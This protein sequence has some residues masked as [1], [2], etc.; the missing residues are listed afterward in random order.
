MPSCTKCHKD[1]PVAEFRKK[2]TSERRN[3]LCN[4]C[5]DIQLISFKRQ[6][7][8]NMA[9]VL[10]WSRMSY[11]RFKK[12]QLTSIHVQ[13]FSQDYIDTALEYKKMKA[14]RFVNS[15]TNFILNND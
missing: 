7:K 13:F 15:Q 3:K 11:N 14:L 8:Q 5:A 6:K 12:N 4:R 1:K 10:Y 2:K 9:K